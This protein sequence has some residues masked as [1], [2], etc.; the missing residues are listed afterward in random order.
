MRPD[1]QLFLHVLGATALFGAVGTVAV[2]GLAARRTTEQA[3]LARAAL[4]ATLFVAVPSWALM[5]IFGSWTKAREGWPGGIAW[6]ELGSGIAS[7]GILVLL[8][9]SGLAYWWLRRPASAWQPAAIGA[10]STGYL[11]ALGVAWWVMTAKVPT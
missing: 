1:T 3:A 11:V 2:L 4:V 8:A 9:T 6:I 10:V 5:L 7:A